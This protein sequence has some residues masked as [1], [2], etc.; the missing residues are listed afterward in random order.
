VD[1]KLDM[2]KQGALAAWKYN[3]MLGCIKRRDDQQ[4]KGDDCPPFS[5]LR[6]PRPV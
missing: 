6:R 5:V 3:Y 4:G 2:S 1:E